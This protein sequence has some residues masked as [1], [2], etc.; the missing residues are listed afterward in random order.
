MELY[1]I[2]RGNKLEPIKIKQYLRNQ[3]VIVVLTLK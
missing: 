1:N 3:S 2:K